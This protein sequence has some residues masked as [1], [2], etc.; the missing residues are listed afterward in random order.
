MKSLIIGAIMV[1]FIII[2]LVMNRLFLLRVFFF[3]LL[4]LEVEGRL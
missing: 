4:P 3:F 2:A 1:T